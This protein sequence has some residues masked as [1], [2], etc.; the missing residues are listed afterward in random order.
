ML[1]FVMIKS[2]EWWFKIYEIHWLQKV[3]VHL[4]IYYSMYITIN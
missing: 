3:S 1:E 2:V 4:S